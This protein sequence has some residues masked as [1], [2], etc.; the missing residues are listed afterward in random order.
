MMEYPRL[1]PSVNAF[2]IRRQGQ[3]LICLQDPELIAEKLLFLPEQATFLVSLFNGQNSVLDVQAAYTRRFG[4][5]I[6][7]DT[8]QQLIAQLDEHYFLD[9]QRCAERRQALERSFREASERPAAHAGQ[10]YHADAEKLRY[11][12]TGFFTGRDGPAAPPQPGDAWSRRRRLSGIIAPH[13]DLR[14]GGP[15]YAWAYKELAEAERPDLFIIFGTCHSPLRTFFALTRKH[16][17][18]PLGT[19]R[20]DQEFLDTLLSGCGEDLLSEEMVHKLEHTIEFQTLFLQH[21]FGGQGPVSILPILVAT[22]DLLPDGASSP[23]EVPQIRA[24]LEHLRAG[25]AASGKRVCLVASVD[26]CHIGQRYG[27]PRPPTEGELRG[28]AAADRD[29]LRHAEALDAEAFFRSAHP[30]QERRRICGLAPIYAFLR[31]IEA[32]EG[33]LLRYSF[34]KQLEANGGATVSYCSM[35]FS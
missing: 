33:R 23:W 6:A 10:S 1:R 34:I 17:Q 20:T 21:L 15:C 30:H 27:D 19:L 8:I 22:F 25:I 9:S 11:Q 13:I 2:P 31:T 4:D 24:F 18:T 3:Q 12:L 5:L 32:S 26:L 35:S 14:F 28:M 16:F 29:L 7:S